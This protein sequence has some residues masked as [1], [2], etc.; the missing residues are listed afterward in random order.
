MRV[1]EGRLAFTA[2][3]GTVADVRRP[4]PLIPLRTALANVNNSSSSALFLI[5]AF[6]ILTRIAS[7]RTGEKMTSITADVTFLV[8]FVFI[9]VCLLD[10]LMRCS[11][12]SR[13]AS[14]L[15]P[16]CQWSNRGFSG[17]VRWSCSLRLTSV[18]GPT[19]EFVG[20]WTM[21]FGVLLRIVRCRLRATI[22]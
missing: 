21:M 5:P 16:L 22:T 2:V 9:R 4:K 17:F 19:Q 11:V 12:A 3:S 8:V 7:A 20:C 13:R 1:P 6:W 14:R 15:Q 18:G 10:L